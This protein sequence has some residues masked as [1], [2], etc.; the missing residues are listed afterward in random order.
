[1][2][3][4]TQPPPPGATR[5]ANRGAFS[6]RTAFIF[7]AIGSAVGLGNIWRFP[8]VA[9]ENGGGAFILPYL[10]ALLTAGIPLLFLD[11]AIGHRWRGSAP[12]S[13]R[14]FRRW[15]E[16]IGWWQVLICVII[17]SYYALILAWA[18]NYT[19][20]SVDVRW[21]DDPAGFF[22]SFTR[23]LEGADATVAF[24]YVPAVLITCVLVWLA[25]I[26]VMVFGVQKGIAGSA[27]VFIP[28]LVIMFIILVVRALMLP[29]A[30]GGLDAF[31]RPNWEALLSP[32][33]WVAAYGQI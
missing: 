3:A 33:V 15:T 8:A 26:A 9:Y 24:D 10:V 16:F 28:L 32:P 25:V 1:M 31:F 14:R 4:S 2:S 30:L 13:W 17:A 27:M 21:G 12:A 18:L 6:G 19:V 5:R 29:G 11:Y 20:F 7:A 23:S 22:G